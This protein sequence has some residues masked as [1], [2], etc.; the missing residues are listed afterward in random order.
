MHTHTY[1]RICFECGKRRHHSVREREREEDREGGRRE[2][3][4]TLHHCLTVHMGAHANT[5]RTV[6]NDE[7]ETEEDEPISFWNVP[8]G[9]G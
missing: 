5:H 9:H 4:Y 6:T 1:M 2:L 8:E 7:E 3:T